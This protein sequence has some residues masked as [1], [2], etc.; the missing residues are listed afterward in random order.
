MIT[1]K[2]MKPQ[3]LKSRPH[4]LYNKNKKIEI[5]QFAQNV[6]ASTVRGAADSGRLNTVLCSSR[7][8]NWSGNW[9]ADEHVRVIENT[10]VNCQSVIYDVCC[11]QLMFKQP[12]AIRVNGSGGLLELDQYWIPNT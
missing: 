5:R 4:K 9:C 6:A 8:T 7:F 10:A 1:W 3:T 11:K 2:I 12:P